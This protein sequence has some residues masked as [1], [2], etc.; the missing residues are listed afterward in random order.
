MHR[1]S[2][3]R[4]A[5]RRPTTGRPRLEGDPEFRQSVQ[6]AFPAARIDIRKIHRELKSLGDAEGIP[7]FEVAAALN[8]AIRR[9][10]QDVYFD[11]ADEH[12]TARGHEIAAQALAEQ[13]TAGDLLTK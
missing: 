3:P 4:E 12:W 7:T 13:L 8:E 11:F 5:T 6:E 1:C 10:E 2:S 9:G